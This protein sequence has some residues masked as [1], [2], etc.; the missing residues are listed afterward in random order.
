MDTMI[1]T[2]QRDHFAWYTKNLPEK[3]WKAEDYAKSFI[4][5]HSNEKKAYRVSAIA[6]ECPS[7]IDASG[8]PTSTAPENAYRIVVD[9]TGGK[10][11]A[12]GCDFDMSATLHDYAKRVIFRAF[13]HAKGRLKLEKTPIETQTIKVWVG[14][15]LLPGNT[16]AVSD[17]WRY[18]GST[19]EIILYWHLIDQGQINPGDK[20]KIE[21][22]VS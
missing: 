5:T 19:N 3:Y 15:V 16:G 9:K 2:H 12:T 13:V 11:Y 4:A 10:Y 21:Y 1:V 8:D 7:L 17:K 20:I 22:R 14:N 6:P 18:D